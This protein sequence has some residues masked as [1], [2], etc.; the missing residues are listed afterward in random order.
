MTYTN[1]GFHYLL[2]IILGV[3]NSQFFGSLFGD[4]SAIVTYMRHVGWNL[5]KVDQ[6]GSNIG[7]DQKHD[8]PLLCNIGNGTMVSDGL[9]M[10]NVRCRH[11][12]Q[13]CRV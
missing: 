3:S 9:K 7:T 5:N 4:S 10:I 12:V 8:N 11:V 1:F 13:A 2:S 6:T